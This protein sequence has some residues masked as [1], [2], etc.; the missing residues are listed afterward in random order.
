M[1]FTECVCVDHRISIWMRD[2]PQKNYD[3]IKEVK[4]VLAIIF[5]NFLPVSR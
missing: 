2:R 1:Q 4:M 3:K 5:D